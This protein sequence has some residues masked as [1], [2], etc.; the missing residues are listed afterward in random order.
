M[1][2]AGETSQTLCCCKCT[3][4]YMGL[5]LIPHQAQLNED[6]DHKVIK[7]YSK[8]NIEREYYRDCI[9]DKIEITGH[10]AKCYNVHV[11]L[12][13]GQLHNTRNTHVQWSSRQCI[14]DVAGPAV[15][16][17]VNPDRDRRVHTYICTH[18]HHEN[19][20]SCRAL[21]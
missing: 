18:A 13:I 20:P 7:C 15:R 11:T 2:I 8:C 5:L 16:T 17:H 1:G 3:A 19:R 6:W 14:S 9:K 10:I 4:P 21:R 12:F